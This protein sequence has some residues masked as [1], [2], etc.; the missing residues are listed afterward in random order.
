MEMMGHTLKVELVEFKNGMSFVRK[1]KRERGTSLSLNLWYWHFIFSFT[2]WFPN[3]L[4]TEMLQGTQKTHREYFKFG[5]KLSNTWDLPD[6]M[7]ITSW[8]K[9]LFRLDCTILLSVIY[10]WE[11]EFLECLVLKASTMQKSV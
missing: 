6:T 9:S 3:W 5:G 8:K 4:S 11:A 7:W 1:R 10:F 2:P